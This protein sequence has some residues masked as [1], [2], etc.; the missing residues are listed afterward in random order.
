MLRPIAAPISANDIPFQKRDF[1][2][3]FILS[4]TKDVCA[5]AATPASVTMHSFAQQ[6]DCCGAIALRSTPHGDP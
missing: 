5:S 6:P 2:H 1:N 4:E 3:A